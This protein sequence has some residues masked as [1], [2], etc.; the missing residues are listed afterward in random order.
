M[1]KWFKIAI[2]AI[3]VAIGLAKEEKIRG[4]VGDKLKKIDP[5][6]LPK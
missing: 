2:A 6:K 4:W 1:G 3:S 5:E